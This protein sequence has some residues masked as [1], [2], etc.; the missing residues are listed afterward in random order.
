MDI[1]EQ[2]KQRL[3]KLSEQK[4]DELHTLSTAQQKKDEM[5]TLSIVQQAKGMDIPYQTFMKYY[6]GVSE[7]PASNLIKIAKYYNVSVNYLLGLDTCE[8]PENEEIS[9]KT[10]LSDKAINTLVELQGQKNMDVK[11]RRYMLNYLIENIHH[12][13]IEPERSFTANSRNLFDDMYSFIFSTIKLPLYEEGIKIPYFEEVITLDN[14]EQQSVYIPQKS[15]YKQIFLLNI[16]RTL[17]RMADKVQR[18]KMK[19]EY[20]KEHTIKEWEQLLKNSN[21]TEL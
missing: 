5:Y 16:Q 13:G 12:E 9:K 15:D 7:C 18:D 11:K 3:E 20:L 14:G 6:N 1:K 8:T 10:G 4:K 19:K 21:L 17:N 2:L